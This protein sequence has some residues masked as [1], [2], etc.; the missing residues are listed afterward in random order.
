[1]MLCPTF[2]ASHYDAELCTPNPESR[3]FAERCNNACQTFVSAHTCSLNV[4]HLHI[5]S[6]TTAEIAFSFFLFYL[7]VEG[8]EHDL[9]TYDT[10]LNSPNHFVTHHKTV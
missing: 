3:P 8:S 2:L 9:E 5:V 4:I 1:M 10:W 6:F 7:R